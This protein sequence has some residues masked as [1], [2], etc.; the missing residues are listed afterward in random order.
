MSL[1]NSRQYA[2]KRDFI[3]MK[4]DTQIILTTPESGQQHQGICRDLSGAGMS[5]EVDQHF[6]ADTE[7]STI[8]PS[9]NEAFKSFNAVI[10]VIRCTDLGNQKFLMGAEIISL[11]DE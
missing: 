8:L 3:R 1:S 7:L 10:R 2:E 11:Q 9:N 4:I 5:V 6:P